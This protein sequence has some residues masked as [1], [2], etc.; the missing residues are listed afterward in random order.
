MKSIAQTSF[1]VGKSSTL[2]ASYASG[3]VFVLF[4]GEVLQARNLRQDV[5]DTGLAILATDGDRPRNYAVVKQS[6]SAWYTYYDRAMVAADAGLPP[7]KWSS[8][9]YG[10][11]PCGVDPVCGPRP[12]Q[13]L[14][15]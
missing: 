10:F 9:R 1:Y 5:T 14:G 7:E 8:L 11:A 2:S 4:K 6:L 3:S 15:L 13:V 12:M